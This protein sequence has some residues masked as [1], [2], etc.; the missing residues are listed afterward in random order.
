MGECALTDTRLM[1][2]DA[3]VNIALYPSQWLGYPASSSFAVLSLFLGSL[4]VHRTH[5]NIITIQLRLL[6]EAALYIHLYPCYFLCCIIF[7]SCFSLTFCSVLF[8]VICANAAGFSITLSCE[9]AYVIRSPPTQKSVPLS[10][11]AR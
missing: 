11:R 2:C 9:C 6:C 1:R 7:A 5:T 8:C 10:Q 4:I 3:D